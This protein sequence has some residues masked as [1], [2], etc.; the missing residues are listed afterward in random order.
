MISIFCQLRRCFLCQQPS[1]F[2][3]SFVG[4][5]KHSSYLTK[6]Q[7][8]IV[9]IAIYLMKYLYLYSNYGCMKLTYQG[10]RPIPN[11]HVQIL[12]WFGIPFPRLKQRVHE[13]LQTSDNMKACPLIQ[14]IG[15]ILPKIF[16]LTS[17]N[18]LAKIWYTSRGL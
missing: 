5:L 4:L 3:M 7:L 8:N 17:C 11:N 2:L 18:S 1:I 6:Q 13:N 10:K 14:L 16:Y 9:N 15:S 12:V